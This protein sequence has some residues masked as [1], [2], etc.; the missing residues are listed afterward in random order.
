MSKFPI[1]WH[2]NGLHAMLEHLDNKVQT[3]NRMTVEVTRLRQEAERYRAQIEE[4]KA[5]G[6]TEFDPEKFGKKRTRA[7]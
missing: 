7:A 1:A 5:R 3:L 2:E 6:V 4:A